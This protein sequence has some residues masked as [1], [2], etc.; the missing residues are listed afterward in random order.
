MPKL[1]A[2]HVPTLVYAIAVAL[3]LVI[4]LHLIHKH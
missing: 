2:P 3:A 4:V 1:A